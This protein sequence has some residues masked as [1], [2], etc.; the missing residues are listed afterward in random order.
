MIVCTQCKGQ[1]NPRNMK[2]GSI[3]QTICLSGCTAAMIVALRIIQYYRFSPITTTAPFE[4]LKPKDRLARLMKIGLQ[5]ATQTTPPIQPPGRQLTF[6]TMI[7]NEAKYIRE[8]VEFHS[9]LGVHRFIIFDNESKDS[10]HLS[11]NGT[12]ADVTIVRWPPVPWADNDNPHKKDCEAYTSRVKLDWWAYASCQRAAFHVCA[13][14]ERG[15]SRWIAAVDIDEFFLPKYDEDGLHSLPDALTRYEHLDGFLQVPFHYGTSGYQNAIGDDELMIETHLLRADRE[16]P[17]NYKEF[18]NPSHI[19]TY[20]S[21]HMATHD[22]ATQN[23]YRELLL[24]P[25]EHAHIRFNHYRF[26]SVEEAR[27]K[28]VKNMNEELW[29]EIQKW[30]SV[31]TYDPYMI[32]M[33]PLVKRRIAGERIWIRNKV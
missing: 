26:R 28:G 12:A 18:A 23:M 19:V 29:H 15:R 16:Y 32:P 33:V 5:T 6:C 4:D 27:H 31:S 20:N 22:R 2:R 14:N 30:N 9:L 25:R 10:P 7:K 8:W 1:T 11:L 13:R 24:T 17:G 3:K 21:V